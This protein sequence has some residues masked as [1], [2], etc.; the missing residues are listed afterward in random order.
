MTLRAQKL[1]MRYAHKSD[2]TAVCAKHEGHVQTIHLLC[3][4]LWFV[5]QIGPFY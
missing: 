1:K 2:A 5:S 4:Y 3:S